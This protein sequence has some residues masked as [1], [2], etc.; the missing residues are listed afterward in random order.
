MTLMFSASNDSSEGLYKQL[1]VILKR[2]P[3]VHYATVKKLIGHLK[4][5]TDHN[6]EN[7]Q[8]VGNVAKV[9]LWKIIIEH[10]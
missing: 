5:V 1:F 8:T 9:G 7:K 3:L 2:L 10:F 4:T 6:L